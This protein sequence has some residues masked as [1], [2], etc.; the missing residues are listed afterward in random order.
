MTFLFYIHPES[1]FILLQW[2]LSNYCH[3]PFSLSGIA[4]KE[5]NHL[6][7]I[8]STRVKGILFSFVILLT[9]A[10]S[11]YIVHVYLSY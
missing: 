11:H 2:I 7:T 9:F 4:V 5:R 10:N 6:Y 3:V 8:D 1:V